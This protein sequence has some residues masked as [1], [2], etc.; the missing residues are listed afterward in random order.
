[1]KHFHI[2]GSSFILFFLKIEKGISKITEAG[3]HF[4]FILNRKVMKIEV[5]DI[6]VG[7]EVLW[8]AKRRFRHQ[9]PEGP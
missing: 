5:R 7:R 8:E 4:I 3:K 2:F 9:K 1:L 6:K